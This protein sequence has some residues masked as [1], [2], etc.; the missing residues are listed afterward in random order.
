MPQVAENSEGQAEDQNTAVSAD[1]YGLTPDERST[2]LL[3]NTMDRHA[4]LSAFTTI[5]DREDTEEDD[6]PDFALSMIADLPVSGA[7]EDGPSPVDTLATGTTS[8]TSSL[9]S[10]PVQDQLVDGIFTSPLESFVLAHTGLSYTNGQDETLQADPSRTQHSAFSYQPFV[11]SSP[12]K[13][14]GMAIDEASNWTLR[15]A[16]PVF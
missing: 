7:D 10:P 12:D 14:S 6:L 4:L 1:Q 15:M 3:P 5:G 11:Y 13:P 9:A 2:A 8:A 16:S